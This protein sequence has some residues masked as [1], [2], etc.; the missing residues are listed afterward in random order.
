[1][2]EGTL[3]TMS[4]WQYALFWI[5]LIGMALGTDWFLR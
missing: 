2:P 4:W 5:G 1:M 3:I